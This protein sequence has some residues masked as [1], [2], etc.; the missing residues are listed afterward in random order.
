[1]SDMNQ[2]NKFE[3]E[4][5]EL[6]R[7][8]KAEAFRLNIGADESVS[9]NTQVFE[10]APKAETDVPAQENTSNEITSFS[11]ESTRAQI[12]RDSKRQ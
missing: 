7:K 11:N 5:V 8:Q 9:D 10:R 6:Y 2:R 4:Q 12:E 3:Q 1:M